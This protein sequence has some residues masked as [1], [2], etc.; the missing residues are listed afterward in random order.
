MCVRTQA[1]LDALRDTA[2]RRDAAH[3]EHTLVVEEGAPI[4]L[5]AA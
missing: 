5:T 1:E 2:D 3:F 4:L